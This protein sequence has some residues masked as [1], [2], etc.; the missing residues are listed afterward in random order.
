M[1]ITAADQKEAKMKRNENSLRNLWDN[2]K[3]TNIYCIG[4]PEKEGKQKGAE[5]SFREILAENFP[6]LGRKR[7]MQIKITVRHSIT[8][9]ITAVI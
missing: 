6:N 1:E 7:E 2:I 5:N 3:Y 4:F 9:V 8:P